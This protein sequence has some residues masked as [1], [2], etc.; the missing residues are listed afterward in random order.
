MTNQELT[1]AGAQPLN[2][3]V[4]WCRTAINLGWN[5]RPPNTSTWVYA[6]GVVGRRIHIRVK[7]SCAV[8]SIVSEDSKRVGVCEEVI[9]G[10]TRRTVLL[11][12]LI[13]ALSSSF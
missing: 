8:H 6:H 4:R 1:F 12:N 10:C 11:T 3:R 9:S 2:I 13:T 5:I 7:P